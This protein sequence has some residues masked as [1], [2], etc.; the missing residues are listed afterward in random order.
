VVFDLETTGLYPFGGDEITSVSAVIVENGRVK[1]DT[2]FDQLVNPKRPIP[3]IATEITG[4]TD[5]MVSNAPSVL[6]VLN[7]FLDFSRNSILVA[8]CADFD[9]NFINLKLKQFC[10]T[11][12]SHRIVDT[13]VLSAALLTGKNCQTL[14][15]L[16]K[17]FEIPTEGRHTSLGDSLMTAEILIR[18]LHILAE[19]DIHTL[20]DLSAYLRWRSFQ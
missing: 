2:Y 12:I 1:Q 3:P 17:F 11:K 5:D 19:R 13:Y 10:H 14:D 15:S 18:F 7:E 16:L 20:E 9:L 8:H 4:I 6:W